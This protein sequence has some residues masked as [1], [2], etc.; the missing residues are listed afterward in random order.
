MNNESIL[1]KNSDEKIDG[2]FVLL[3]NQK[4]EIKGNFKISKKHNFSIFNLDNFIKFMFVLAVFSGMY[5]FF[6]Q[7]GMLSEVGMEFSLVNTDLK[8]IYYFSYIGAASIFERF[9]EFSINIKWRYVFY[10]FL[11]FFIFGVLFT[12]FIRNEEVVNTIK[13]KKNIFFG[14][15]SIRRCFRSYIFS[16][17]IFS[18]FGFLIYIFQ[19]FSVFI[20]KNIILFFIGI[21]LLPGLIGHGNGVTYMKK[22]M[23]EGFCSQP[24]YKDSYLIG[25]GVCPF[26]VIRGHYIW[27]DIVL[28]TP[29]FYYIRR[30]RY[31]LKVNK[32]DD[33]C[34]F[35]FYSKGKMKVYL[36]SEVESL[37]FK[38]IDVVKAKSS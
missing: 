35:S 30:E 9:L 31:F 32:K 34:L 14:C 20:L 3:E 13:E 26:L 16:S 27:G 21:I 4:N 15:L 19:F 38:K 10:V 23:G 2:S 18:L 12:F 1:N 24:Q 28:E 5:G 7:K 29:D 36:D 25:D 22:V 33:N 37:C 6:F 17:F 11:C 8:S